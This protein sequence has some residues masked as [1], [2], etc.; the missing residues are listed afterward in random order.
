LVSAL[1]AEHHINI[2][3][4]ACNTA[5]TI[6][7]P[8]LRD[9]LSVPVVGVVPAIKPASLLATQGVGLIATPATVTRQYTHELIR[10][11]AQGKPVELLG[12]TRLVDMAEEKLRG[13]SV[14]LDELKSILSP[15]CNKVDVAVLGCT[16][17]PLIKSEIQQVLGSNV[18][19]IDSGEAIARRVKA[20]LSCDELEEKE[21]GIKRIFASAPPWQEDALN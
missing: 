13:D 2:V 12:S 6:V 17:F 3:V 8:S 21:E 20:L 14:P 15:L 18:V 4:I 11:F 16:H 9:N 10:D 5:S 19:L 1:V 7:L